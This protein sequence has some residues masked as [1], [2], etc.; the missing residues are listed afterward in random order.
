M[1]WFRNSL[2][3][4]SDAKEF[5]CEPGTLVESLEPVPFVWREKGPSGL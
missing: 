3:L 4:L 5:K 2:L 1:D